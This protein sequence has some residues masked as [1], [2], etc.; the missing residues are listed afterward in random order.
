M[1]LRLFGYTSLTLAPLEVGRH[2]TFNS[3]FLSYRL[4]AGLQFPNFGALARRLCLGF[5]DFPCHLIETFGKLSP[6]FR[7]EACE[8]R[9][10]K[11]LVW[12]LG[13]GV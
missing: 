11:R 1:V 13:L 6:G 8:S 7:S 10:C 4:L 2:L 12:G 9:A 5:D 3:S